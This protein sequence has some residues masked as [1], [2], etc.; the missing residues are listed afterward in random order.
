MVESTKITRLEEIAINA[1]PALYTQIYDGWILRYANGY[2]YRAN[3]VSPLYKSKENI[4]TKIAYCEKKYFAWSLPCVFKM[5]KAV[6]DQLDK[7]LEK[8]GYKIEAETKIYTLA[9]ADKWENQEIVCI[10]NCISTGWLEQF[11]KL[12]GTDTEPYKS[13]AMKITS[14]IQNPVICASICEA[15]VIVGCGLGVV[16]GDKVGLFDIRVS[17]KY[18][19]KGYGLAICKQIINKAYELGARE[20]YLQVAASNVGAIKMYEKIGYTFSHNYWYRVKNN[21]I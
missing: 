17:E 11:T 2:T 10:S 6:P 7:T 4:E 1:H 12:N 20:S 14:L 5:T 19:R 15:G 13:T 18:R 3:S 21:N 8:H 9:I 16:E